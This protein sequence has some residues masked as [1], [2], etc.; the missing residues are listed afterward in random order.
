MRHYETMFLRVVGLLIWEEEW[1]KSG[2]E[3]LR[4][5]AGWL[6]LDVPL[7]DLEQVPR[8]GNGGEKTMVIGNKL[9]AK[10]TLSSSNK[11]IRKNKGGG[12]LENTGSH[13]AKIGLAL[14]LTQFVRLKVSSTSYYSVLDNGT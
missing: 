9:P 13:L 10:R 8:I 4:I 5:S 6:R 11:W 7:Q 12:S 2:S 3:L 14:R 1:G